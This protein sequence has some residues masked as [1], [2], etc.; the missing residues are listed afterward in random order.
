[1]TSKNPISYAIQKCALSCPRWTIKQVINVGHLSVVLQKTYV[2][3]ESTRMTPSP[4]ILS[5]HC[6]QRTMLRFLYVVISKQSFDSST[7]QG[8]TTS[9]ERPFAAGRLQDTIGLGN[10]RD[11]TE[12]TNVSF[13]L[14]LSERASQFKQYLLLR[15]THTRILF[16]ATRRCL[17]I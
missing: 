3:H 15:K 11:G 4:S 8:E 17:S 13:R 6:S 10:E 14:M 16:D 1:M 2:F 7:D 5:T 12:T 9:V